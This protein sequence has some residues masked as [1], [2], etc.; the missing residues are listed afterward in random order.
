MGNATESPLRFAF[1][2][3]PPRFAGF[4]ANGGEAEDDREGPF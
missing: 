4:R 1:G 2:C 3:F